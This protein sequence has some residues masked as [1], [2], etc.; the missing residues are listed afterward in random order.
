MTDPLH[1]ASGIWMDGIEVGGMDGMEG[2]DGMVD[3]N[4]G[5][6]MTIVRESGMSDLLEVIGAGGSLMRGRETMVAGDNSLVEV[7]CVVPTCTHA[8]WYLFAC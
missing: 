3:M 6:R 5:T 8:V 7:G 4:G 2:M 1:L